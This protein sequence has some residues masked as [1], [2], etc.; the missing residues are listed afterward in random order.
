MIKITELNKVYK[1]KKRKK[2][3]ALMDISITLPDNGLVFVL[4]KSGSGKSTLLNIIGG[5]DS[6]TSGRV[7]V[8]GNDLSAF[9]ERDFCNYRNN[10]IGFIFQDYHLIDELTIYDNI[11]LSLNLRR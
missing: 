1:S 9:R 6:I 2:C 8:D 4:G 7:V 3:H 11:V 5:L 10:H